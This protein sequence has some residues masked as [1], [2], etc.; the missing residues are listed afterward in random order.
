MMEQGALDSRETLR[1]SR[2]GAGKYG[3][4]KVKGNC[5]DEPQNG[6]GWGTWAWRSIERSVRRSASRYRG[7]MTGPVTFMDNIICV[8][9]LIRAI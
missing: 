9:I 3:A 2:N 1:H 6:H 8:T 4:W 5:L 7:G